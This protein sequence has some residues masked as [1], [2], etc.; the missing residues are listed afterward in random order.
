[1]STPTLAE[2]VLKN[3]YLDNIYSYASLMNIDVNTLANTSHVLP[4][5]VAVSKEGVSPV[6]LIIGKRLGIYLSFNGNAYPAGHK[7]FNYQGILFFKDTVV[8]NLNKVSLLKVINDETQKITQ[9]T[10]SLNKAKERKAGLENLK[11]NY[12][13]FFV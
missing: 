3:S 13:E 11:T 6:T 2:W 9:Y 10:R 8:Y 7:Y 1:M 12:P 4:N 5:T